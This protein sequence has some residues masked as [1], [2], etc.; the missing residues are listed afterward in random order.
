M[1]HEAGKRLAPG[2]RFK[3]GGILICME[4]GAGASEGVWVAWPNATEN[5]DGRPSLEPVCWDELELP[6]TPLSCDC[7]GWR[8]TD[9]GVSVGGLVVGKS[10]EVPPDPDAEHMDPCPVCGQDESFPGVL[11]SPC[12]YCGGDGYGGRCPRC[13]GDGREPR[14]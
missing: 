8:N 11:L 10:R 5:H 9:I 13:A 14:S 6:D 3:G 12:S 2:A 7:C 1:D 4:A